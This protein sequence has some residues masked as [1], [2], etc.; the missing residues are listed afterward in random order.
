MS[1]IIEHEVLMS[2][3][4]VDKAGTKYSR[5]APFDDCDGA[6][7]LKVIST[8]GS[9]TV[10]QQCSIDDETF[11]DPETAAGAAGAVEDTLTVTT[12]R[13]ISFTPVIAPFIRFKVVEGNVAASAVTLELIKRIAV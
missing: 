10:T 12:G 7:C 8:A 1:N 9:I 5:S 11:Y 2:V 6:A 3:V 4:T 13:Y